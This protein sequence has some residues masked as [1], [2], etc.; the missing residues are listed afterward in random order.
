MWQLFSSI[1]NNTDDNPENM[2]SIFKGIFTWSFAITFITCY[3]IYKLFITPK[4]LLL[5]YKKQG[6]R[7]TYFP[8]IGQL[9]AMWNYVWSR[10][11]YFSG[12]KTMIL[13]NPD[14]VANASNLR[15]N[16]ILEIVDLDLFK[17]FIHKQDCYVKSKQ[18][19]GFLPELIPNSLVMNHTETWKDQVEVLEKVFTPKLIRDSL[20]SLREIARESFS[21]MAK[22]KELNDVTIL[23][24]ILRCAGSMIGISWFGDKFTEY[25]IHGKPLAEELD[26]IL[27]EITQVSVSPSALI[28]GKFFRYGFL[29]KHR[30]LLNR[31]RAIRSK[32]LEIIREEKLEYLKNKDQ[33]VNR[34]WM[35]LLMQKQENSPV[36]FKDADLLDQFLGF[37][38]ES[39][40]TISHSVCMMLYFLALY[41]D[42]KEK[43]GHEFDVHYEGK[44]LTLDALHSLDF[45]EA[46]IKEVLRYV[47]PSSGTLFREATKDHTLAGF[48]VKKGTI[49]VAQFI[50][51]HFNPKY[52]DHPEKF[53]VER[54]TSPD[55]KSMKSDSLSVMP[56]SAGTRQCFGKKI[57]LAN[58]EFKILLGEF[59]RKFDFKLVE[60]YTA[61]MGMTFLYEPV[62]PVKMTL[63]PKAMVKENWD[64]ENLDHSPT[65]AQ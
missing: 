11:D 9:G 3:L 32:F 25:T 26:E 7:T 18:M 2:D 8:I 31:I 15:S 23:K 44:E 14:L 27:H 51:I 21:Q 42:Y 38:I 58:G 52:H 56:F 34:N 35:Q 17:D 50:P 20:P 65:A 55:S 62:T 46:F 5:F 29:P 57:G 39:V 4:L 63:T 36:S 43:M 19:L 59:I 47:P 1:L 6:A 10:G 49:V 28:F 45:T 30:H 41:P 16:V 61:K 13:N 12:H 33:I 60:G 53:S 64:T 22:E 48:K 54:W 24:P 37:F 40:N